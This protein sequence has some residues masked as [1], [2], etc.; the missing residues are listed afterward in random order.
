[1]STQTLNPAYKTI[2]NHYTIQNAKKYFENCNRNPIVVEEK[3]D[4]KTIDGA[5][6]CTKIQNHEICIFG[7]YLVTTHLIRYKNLP[8]VKIGF[9]F[10]IDGKYLDPKQKTVIL[11]LLGIVPAPIFHIFPTYD[12]FSEDYVQELYLRRKSNFRTELNP[13]ICEKFTNLCKKFYQNYGNENFTEGVVAKCYNNGEMRAIKYVK[14]EFDEIIKNVGPYERYPQENVIRYNL[15]FSKEI[16]KN[17]LNLLNLKENEKRIVLDLFEK[18]YPYSYGKIKA[19]EI[20]K[21]NPN[22]SFLEKIIKKLEN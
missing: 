5:S 22:L 21:Y 11:A 1:M 8:D 16:V 17:N 7:E 14:K 3:L 15:E 10:N 2:H 12:Q 20:I 9:D 4:G 13:K 19:E 18:S 6:A